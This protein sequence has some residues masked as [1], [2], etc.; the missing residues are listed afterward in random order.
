MKKIGDIFLTVLGTFLKI[1]YFWMPASWKGYRT[2]A[3]T[4]LTAIFT[5]L[6]SL[7]LIDLSSRICAAAESVAHIWNPEF[8]CDVN[9]VMSGVASYIGLVLVKLR[10]ET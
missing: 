4:G 8:V 2:Y 6:D 10:S 1:P 3:I 5:A 9:S 7:N